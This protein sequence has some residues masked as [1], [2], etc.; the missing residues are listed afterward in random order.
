MEFETPA[1]SIQRVIDDKYPNTRLIWQ[2]VH[3]RNGARPLGGN[4]NQGVFNRSAPVP[5]TRP[6]DQIREDSPTTGLDTAVPRVINLRYPET[7]QIW[8][9]SREEPAYLQ[10]IARRSP[11]LPRLYTSDDATGNSSG[12]LVR[13]PA[14]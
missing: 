11:G 7:R 13:P 10:A 5:A 9:Q 2:N 6:W 4:S 3:A 1:R 12:D 8:V 14:H